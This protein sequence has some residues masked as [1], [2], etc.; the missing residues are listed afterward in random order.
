LAQFLTTLNAIH[1]FREGNGRTQLTFVSLLATQADHPL[2]LERL[3]PQA[4]LAAMIA[5]FNGNERPLAK[6]LLALID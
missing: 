4:F 5:G 1:P 3:E 2:V 6:T